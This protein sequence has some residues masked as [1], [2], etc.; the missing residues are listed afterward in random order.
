IFLVGVWGA[1]FSFI[2][3]VPCFPVHIFWDAIVGDAQGTC[4]GFADTLNRS[5]Y[6]VHAASNMFFDVLIF[7]IPMTLPFDK[8]TPYK[9]R[10]GMTFLLMLGV[11]YVLHAPSSVVIL[12]KL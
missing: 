1:G 3:W 8:S 2:A 11:L 6:L 10:L 12:T 9:Q 7:A 4:Y 5:T